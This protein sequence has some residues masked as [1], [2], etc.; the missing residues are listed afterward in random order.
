MPST[1]PW[2][3]LCAALAGAACGGKSA[4]STDTPAPDPTPEPAAELTPGT[5]G[6]PGLDWGD[7]RA[8]VKATYPSAG[9][10]GEELWA[11]LVHG[12]RDA[13]ASFTFT[14]E[15]LSSISV[16]YDGDF[17]DMGA[18]A[19]PLHAV[20]AELIKALGDSSE[21]NLAVFWTTPTAS[22]TLSCDPI[23][24]AGRAQLSASFTLAEPEG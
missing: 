3:L 8:K 20:E 14:D 15:A 6:F 17:P 7:D 21:E 24:D 10:R 2:T 11:P 12:G 19:D 22:I 13:A 16:A 4:P 18:C 5:S 1:A 9:T 23:D